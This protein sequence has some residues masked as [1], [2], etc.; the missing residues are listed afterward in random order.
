MY[1]IKTVKGD[2]TKIT[3]VQAIVNAAN[4]SLLGGGGV[5]GAIHRAAGPELLAECRT[6]HG[7]ETG[8]AKITKAYNLPCDYVIHTVGP[9]WNGGRNKEEEFLANCYFNSMKLAMENGIRTIA[10]PSISTG[11]Y[12]F[13]VELAANVAVHTVNRFLQDNPD[14]FDLV[15]WVLFDAHTEAVYEAE[16]DKIYSSIHTIRGVLR[17]AFQMAEEDDL[18][19]KNPF[20]FELVNVIVNDSVRREAVTRKQEREFLRF[21]KEDAHFCKYYDAIFILFNTGLRISEFCGLTKSDLDFKNKRIRVNHQLQRTSQM[22]YIIEKPK[23][24]SGERYVPMSDEVMACFKRILKDRVNP[25]VEPMVDGMTGFL[26][27]D[28]NDMPMVALHWEKYFQHIREKYNSIYKVQMPPI[29]PH[30]CRHT[31]CSNMAK[32]GMNPKMLQYIM[33]HSD[34]S[35]TMNTYT[36]VKFQDA[37]E[38]FQKA[39][40][41]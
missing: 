15:E 27:L 20:G 8:E 31:F 23:T 38:D 2:I 24:E 1:I 7:C 3:D 29:T 33:G 34:I 40:N 13:P 18:I 21:I 6:L 25:K 16:V 11:V 17:P 19:R 9:I 36:H 41:S 28:K 14:S 5:D 22:Q 10:F 12:S 26:F 37:Q 32:S 35:V 4:N 30:V 39:I